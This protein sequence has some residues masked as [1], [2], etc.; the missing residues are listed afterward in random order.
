MGFR[1][2]SRHGS[3]PS[4]LNPVPG[5][6]DLGVNCFIIRLR[7]VNEGTSTPWVNGGTQNELRVLLR[8]KSAFTYTN[9]KSPNRFLV[10]LSQPPLVQHQIYQNTYIPFDPLKS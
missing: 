7:V 3:D 2:G 4:C 1:S 10:V 9:I 6:L 5:F 8:P